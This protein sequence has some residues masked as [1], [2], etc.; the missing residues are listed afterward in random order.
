VSEHLEDAG[1]HSG[2]ATLVLPPRGLYL[3]TID[4]VRRM[5]ERLARALEITGPFNIQALS[6]HETV[7]VIECNL[8]ASR[9]FPFVSK[10]LGTNFAAEA[11]R[12]MLGAG[13]TPNTGKNPL[14]F[15]YAAVKAPQFS[16]RRLHGVDPVLG[17]EMASTG[18]VACLG[19]DV[20]EALV[21]AMV[22]A[23]FRIPKSGALLSLGP[24]GDKY[25][26]ADEARLMVERGLRLFATPGT[27]DVLQG[28]GIPCE[29]VEP[30]AD[31]WPHVA[32]LVRRREIDLVINVPRAYDELGR[33]DGFQIRRLAIDLEVPLLVDLWVARRIVRAMLRPD[34]DLRVKPWHAYLSDE[35]RTRVSRVRNGGV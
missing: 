12:L 11:T 6:R 29:R 4:K 18:E 25:R 26:F 2:D 20:D 31:G 33:P 5:A 7:K 19:E 1:V 3:G 32:A 30:R 35:P 16:F 10:V 27:A 9:S 17:V 21:K 28:E 23:G 14:D 13:R 34:L 8:R 22:A 24:V 15:P